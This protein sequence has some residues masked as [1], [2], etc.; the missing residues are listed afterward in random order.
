MKTSASILITLAAAFG[1]AANAW[2]SP[3]TDLFAK[4]FDPGRTEYASLFTKEFMAQVPE[5]KLK[6]I[7][8]LYVGTLGAFQNAVGTS[9]D[10]RLVFEKGEAPGK[11]G[12]D[13]SGRAS[14]LWFGTW[15]LNDDTPEKLRTAFAA[16]PGKVSVCVTRDGG[17]P[18]F[19][20]E[21]DAPLGV[22]SAFKLYV[23]KALSL[24][25]SKGEAKWDDVIRLSSDLMSLPSGSLQSWPAGTPVTLATLAGMMISVSDNT[26]TDH[27]IAHL[28]RAA[29][30]AVA[31]ARVRPFLSTIE[32]FRIKWGMPEKDRQ[33][34]VAASPEERA[35]ILKGLGPVD[36]AAIVPQASPILIDS[37]EWL[38]STR[39]LCQVVYEL[40]D[41][42]YLAINPGL[43]A[44]TKWSL[45]GYKGGSEPGVLNYTHVLRKDAK[46]PV[47]AIAATIN[48]PKAEV[49]TQAFTV[50][51]SRLIGMIG[52][53]GL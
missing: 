8:K 49:D 9:V 18:V 32:M 23:L 1:F 20:M 22:G 39:E 38:V 24:K 30:E 3:E 29:V 17:Q 50:L 31:P 16:L 21:S 37:V 2:A 14:M 19:S 34:Y 26:A 45:A 15:T 41:S 28:G 11:V 43:V 51:V 46:S 6:E 47:Y 42:P 36:R 27:L 44:G 53:K 35:R 48:N 7:V 33:A 4:F 25:V 12:L 5:A 52:R 10:Y 40:K 13:A